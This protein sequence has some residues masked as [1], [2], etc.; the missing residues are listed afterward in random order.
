MNVRSRALAL[1]LA[2]CAGVPPAAAFDYQAHGFVAQG[3]LWSENNNVYGESTE[4]SIEYFEGGLNGIVDLGWGLSAA[5]Q[6]VARRAGNTDDGKP[7][8]DYGFVDYKPLD[9]RGAGV[10]LRAGKVKNEFGFYNAGRDVVF[11]RPGILLP[12]SVYSDIVGQRSVLFSATG[13]QLY[14]DVAFADQLLSFTA[15]GGLDR[16][17]S[18]LEESKLIT[19]TVP[20]ELDLRDFWQ[21]QVLDEIGGDR[22]RFALSYLHANFDLATDIGVSGIFRTDSWVASAQWNAAALSVTAEYTYVVNDN[23]LF[24]AGTPGQSETELHGGYLQGEYRF[25]SHWS[26]LARLDAEISRTDGKDCEEQVPARDEHE[27]GALDFTVG[28]RWS[29]TPQW[30]VW[31]EWHAVDGLYKRSSP[32][33]NPTPADPHWHV[34]LLMVGYRF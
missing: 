20:F 5:A 19:L 15:T 12:D 3:A 34:V 27:C 30:G 22:W 16:E 28:G 7:R 6:M 25:D 17:L 23:T 8:L 4:G 14:G 33:D 31:A 10:G 13:A 11:T 1:L 21:G 18:E 9:L 29:P 32:L 26:A 2:G 24:I